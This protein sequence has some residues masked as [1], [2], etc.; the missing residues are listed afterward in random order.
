MP[1]LSLTVMDTI[2]EIKLYFSP[3]SLLEG[4]IY[5]RGCHPPDTTKVLPAR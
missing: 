3:W 5:P 1:A 4:Q 2:I